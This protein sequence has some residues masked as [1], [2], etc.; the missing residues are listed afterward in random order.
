MDDGLNYHHLRYFWAVAKN[1][2][3]TATAKRMH[4]AQSALSSQIRQLEEQ[5]GEGLFIREGRKLVL[6]EAGKMALVYAESIFASGRELV[7]IMKSGRT[8]AHTLH[9]GAMATLS[10]NFQELFIRPLLDQPEIRLHLVSGSLEQLLGQLVAHELDLVLANR[11]MRREASRPFRSRRVARQR[12]S[13]IGKPRRKPFRFPRD[14][15]G[16]S[17]ILPSSNGE[18]RAAF[19]ALC[20]QHALLVHVRAEVDDMAMMR[21]LARDTDALAL[22]PSVVV[23]DELQQG[24]LQEYCVLPSVQ[25]D[26]YAITVERNFQHPQLSALLSRAASEIL[27]E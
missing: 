17:L 21:L 10:R 8:R 15:Q 7:S 23:R 3:L 27:L 16:A 22:L 6:T 4:V 19:D 20:E 18:L 25:E 1:G 5:L 14:L 12:V 24:I 11:P 26:F 2:N 9:I 13:V